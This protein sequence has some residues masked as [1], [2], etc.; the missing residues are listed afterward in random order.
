M[1]DETMP[2]GKWKFNAD[3]ASV[4]GDMLSRSIPGL[5]DLRNQIKFIVGHTM[6]LGGSILEIGCSDGQQ[7][8]SIKELENEISIIKIYGIDNSQE[9]LDIAHG[10]CGD[11]AKLMNHDITK[12]MPRFIGGPLKYDLILCVLTLQFIPVEL[13]PKILKFIKNSIRNGG[14][15]IFVEKVI[16]PDDDT[17]T[18][19]TKVYHAIK[20]QNGYTLEQVVAKNESLR[21]VLVSQTIES[22]EQML[23]AAGFTSVSTFWQNTAFVGWVAS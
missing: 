11:Y 18:L 17:Q 9:M 15:F 12:G 6:P 20:M 14:R 21:N 2:D 10:K 4:F 1:R 5:S 7:I 13:R 19:L 16:F 22:N 3:V 23:K 8:E